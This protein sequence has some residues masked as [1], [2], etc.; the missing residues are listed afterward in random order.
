MYDST[1]IS[2]VDFL[3]QVQLIFHLTNSCRVRTQI[4]NYLM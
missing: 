2:K 1:K 4:L 3:M